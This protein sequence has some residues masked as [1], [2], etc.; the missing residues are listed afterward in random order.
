M[1]ERV[2]V[3][4]ETQQLQKR[5]RELS[6][7]N[8]IAQALNRE[9]DLSRALQTVLAQVAEWLGLETGWVFLIDE[10][11]GDSYLA[12]HQNLPPALSENPRRMGGTCYCLDTYRA[13]DMDGAAN[14]NV[15]TCSRLKNLVDGTDGLRFHGSI[16][17]YAHGKEV[18]V[19]NVASTDWRELSDEDRR[20][21]YTVGDVVGIAIERARLFARS[22][23][24]GATAE[25]NRLAREIHDTLA[26]GLVAIALRLET[27]DALLEGDM[28]SEGAHEALHQ[29]MS[30]TR[31]SLEEARRSVL[32]L[33]AAALEGRRLVEALGTLADDVAEQAGLE[34]MFDA[35]GAKRSL[36]GRIE[37][38]LFRIAQEA[39][40]N[41]AQHAEAT[42][43]T[44]QLAA[45]S[46]VAQLT[47]QD[48]G[49]GFDAAQVAGG[50]FG[51]IGMNERARLLGGKLDLQSNAG[52]GTRLHVVVPVS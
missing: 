5:N 21:L 40:N 26:Q 8:A 22:A 33:R 9:V 20:L 23:E 15:V 13:G 24:M 2:T 32:D 11:T 34:V 38:G 41:V 52:A 10:E 1:A 28:D 43:L 17:L 6:I 31:E 46:E 12:A 18:G 49:V 4:S 7:L 29:A 19:L 35:T 30:L 39:F 48:D 37:V 25:R 50:S 16:P 14:V 51:L 27:A 44:V 3:E 45:T 42:H 36:P 47:I